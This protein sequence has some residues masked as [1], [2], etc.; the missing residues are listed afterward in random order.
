LNCQIHPGI[1]KRFCPDSTFNVIRSVCLVNFH[2][3]IRRIPF[4]ITSPNCSGRGPGSSKSADH[5]SKRWRPRHR[6]RLGGSFSRPQAFPLTGRTPQSGSRPGPP[7]PTEVI[8]QHP[9]EWPEERIGARLLSTEL[10]TKKR[11]VF[12]SVPKAQMRSQIR[13][14]ISEGRVTAPQCEQRR[15]T[16]PTSLNGSGILDKPQN[17]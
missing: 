1:A 7:D 5:N 17:S 15:S 4:L 16:K 6:L 12:P 11:S 8:A 10:L 13:C 14:L 2:S 3:P 9:P